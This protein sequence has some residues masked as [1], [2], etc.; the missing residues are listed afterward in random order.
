MLCLGWPS[1][2]ESQGGVGTGIITRYHFS[3]LHTFHTR[4]SRRWHGK[5]PSFSAAVRVGSAGV[6]RFL[7]IYPLPKGGVRWYHPPE[8]EP[9]FDRGLV[10][11][12]ARFPSFPNS[13]ADRGHR[14]DRRINQPTMHLFPRGLIFH[15]IPHPS[16]THSG[17][18]SSSK[19]T[20][21]HRLGDEGGGG[22][23]LV[24]PGGGQDTDGL[25]VAGQTV[26]TGLDQNEAELGVLVLAVALE[27][28]A[29][30]DGLGITR[31]WLASTRGA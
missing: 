26:D 30:G 12:S 7:L 14:I 10:A 24:A 18:S 16:S 3:Q 4:I 23:G 22:G 15:S 13:I 1:H 5:S 20:A 17:N 9:F 19:Q 27:V 21:S 25:V 29:D 28:L 2:Q 31:W 11:P 6:L 8:A